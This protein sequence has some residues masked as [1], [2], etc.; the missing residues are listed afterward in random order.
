MAEKEKQRIYSQERGYR[1]KEMFFAIATHLIKASPQETESEIE[2]VLRTVRKRLS[3]NHL[4]LYLLAEAG[5][6]FHARYASN[7]SVSR[8][9]PSSLQ[10]ADIPG[11]VKK[12][13]EHQ[14][15]I[16]KGLPEDLPEFA[17]KDGE[18]MARAGVRSLF[19][20]PILLE[21]GLWGMLWASTLGD[22]EESFPL[23][24]HL[25][26]LR[27]LVAAALQRQKSYLHITGLLKFDHLLSEVSAR[28]INLPVV[29]I[30][31]TVRQDLE[32]LGRHLEAER[33]LL[34]L[35]DDEK[36][37]F[38]IC[39]NK[40]LWYPQEDAEAIVANESF[41]ARYPNFDATYFRYAFDRWKK[42]G[43]GFVLYT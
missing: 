16:L 13:K 17:A 30:E 36:K 12:I 10:I 9:L 24:S 35:L 1:L 41:I 38:H 11:I 42:G 8:L 20:S 26:T 7:E 19:V 37:S 31:D 18:I 40:F 39:A 43:N 25:R 28:Y 21:D 34:Y 15:I 33:C 32:Q 6:V 3:L 27:D 4:Y 14:S 29:E 22:G 5:D 2:G 23:S